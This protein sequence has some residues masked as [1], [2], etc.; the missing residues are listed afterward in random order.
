MLKV[1]GIFIGSGEGQKSRFLM[2]VLEGGT[3]V[4]IFSPKEQQLSLPKIGERISVG[5]PNA[6]MEAK[7]FARSIFLEGADDGDLD[8]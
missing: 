3:I 4:R 2:V 7:I 5:I 6:G 8:L 1:E